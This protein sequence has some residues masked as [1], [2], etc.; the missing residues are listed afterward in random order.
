MRRI[1][2]FLAVAMAV[3]LPAAASAQ[4]RIITGTVT[5]SAT[6]QP[7]PGAVVSVIGGTTESRTSANGQFRLAAPSGAVTVLARAI[8][9]KRVT[10]PVAAGETRVDFALEKDLLLLENV[11][12][13]G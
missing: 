8:G 3:L 6:G 1:P 5:I 2:S 12:V 7:L 11:V 9:Y 4:S 10:K 13:T